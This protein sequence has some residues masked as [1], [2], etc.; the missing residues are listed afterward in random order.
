EGEEIP[1]GK[2]LLS[3]TRTYAPLLKKILEDQF[4][5][6]H[7]IIHCSGG[8]QTKCMKYL[9]DNFRIVKDD[10][11]AVPPVFNLIQSNSGAD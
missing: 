6:I 2:L 7:G 5:D 8:G 10:L 1:I 3:P 9:P 11:F 4:A